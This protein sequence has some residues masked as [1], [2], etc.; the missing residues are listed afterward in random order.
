MS[1]LRFLLGS[2]EDLNALD[3]Y[4]QARTSPQRHSGVTRMGL[5]V[6]GARVSG[7]TSDSER[8]SAQQLVEVYRLMYSRAV[9][10]TAKSC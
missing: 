5:A 4:N 6:S 3:C 7:S 1:P 10:M 2:G 8:L 9:W